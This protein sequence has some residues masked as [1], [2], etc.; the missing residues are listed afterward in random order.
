MAIWERR[1]SRSEGVSEAIS[2]G[3]QAASSSKTSSVSSFSAC[4]RRD[5]VSIAPT[6]EIAA[7]A[8]GGVNRSNA[9]IS[10]IPSESADCLGVP[11]LFLC[12]VIASVFGK[13]GYLTFERG[14][15][16]PPVRKL[17]GTHGFDD[18]ALCKIGS[19]EYR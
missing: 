6:L 4:A 16:A 8:L 5:S 19:V 2:D 15:N 17:D 10:N 13:R 3:A 11:W 18:H 12:T 1:S 9:S 14:A 7:A